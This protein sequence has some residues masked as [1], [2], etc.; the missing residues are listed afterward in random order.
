MRAKLIASIVLESIVRAQP[1][2]PNFPLRLET[3]PGSIIHQHW[4]Y[5]STT[6]IWVLP[7]LLLLS[8]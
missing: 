5:Q 1:A 3:F 4:A 2:K 8:S 7:C 6:F